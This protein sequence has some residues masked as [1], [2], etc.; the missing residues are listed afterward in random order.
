MSGNSSQSAVRIGS[1][2]GHTIK[3]LPSKARFSTRRF[4]FSDHVEQDHGNGNREGENGEAMTALRCPPDEA[5]TQANEEADQDPCEPWGELGQYRHTVR[6]TSSGDD[7]STHSAGGNEVSKAGQVS[8]RQ[9]RTVPASMPGD[10]LFESSIALKSIPAT[11]SDIT[12]PE[13]IQCTAEECDDEIVVGAVRPNGRCL[14]PRAT[15]L[16]GVIG[17]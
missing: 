8:R 4:P 17:W 11:R 15:L 12:H 6:R 16:P 10:F 5:A 7:R 1:V 9:S 14:T 3:V 13:A 2:T